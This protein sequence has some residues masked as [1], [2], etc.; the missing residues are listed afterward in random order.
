[1]GRSTVD[2][3]TGLIA[4]VTEA[5]TTGGLKIGDAVPPASDQLGGL[6]LVV[7]VAG[8]SI[9]ETPGIT[10]DAGDWCLCVNATEGWIR[11]DTLNGGGGGG[12]SSLGDLLDVTLTAEAAGEFIQLQ[13]NGQWQNI[14]LEPGTIGALKPGDNVS[15][16]VNDAGYLVPGDDVSDLN[17]DAGYITSGDIPAGANLWT[18]NTGKVYPTNLSNHVQVG[19]TAADP[20]IQLNASGAASF[21]GPVGIGTDSP[22]GK[23]SVDGVA[24]ANPGNNPLIH[25]SISD[26]PIWAFRSTS[27][28]THL[29]I[30]GYYDGSWKNHVA[31]ERNSGSVGIGGTLP[32]APNISLNASGSAS[33]EG[34][35]G[36]GTDLPQTTLQVTQK[37]DTSAD[38][39]RLTRVGKT[40]AYTQWIDTVARFNIGYSNPATSD[41]A[42]SFVTLTQAGNVGI[43]TDSPAAPLEISDTG[44]GAGQ[45][46]RLERV[47]NGDKGQLHLS[48][49]PD[50]NTVI[51]KAT[52]SSPSSHVF[53][54]GNTE[55]ARIDTEGRLLVG[56]SISQSYGTSTGLVQIVG[57]TNAHMALKRST[58]DVSQCTF[59]FAKSRGTP[60]S[61]AI[62]NNNDV[63]GNLRYAAYDGTDY[64]SRAA[65]IACSVDGPPDTDNL[66]GRLTF[67]TTGSGNSSPTERMRIRSDGNIGIGT[68]GNTKVA[69]Y[70]EKEINYEGNDAKYSILNQPL[71]NSGTSNM[72]LNWSRA[73]WGASGDFTVS[74]ITHFVANTD[75]PPSNV[76]LA[77][78]I[79]FVAASNL[80]GATN[81]YGF[82]SDIASGTGRWNFY[83]NGTAANYFNGNTLFQSTT[84]S[85]IT[86]GA[87]NAKS[88]VASGQM[89]SSRSGTSE[90][91][92]YRFYNPNGEVGSIKTSGNLTIFEE[93]S[94]YRLKEN[95]SP[96]TGA[97]DQLKALKPC[98][99]N[100]KTDPNTTLQG[101]IAHEAQE[102]CPQAVTGA[103]DGTEAIGTLF[104]WDGK[105]REENVTEPAEL[106][107]SEEVIDDPGQEGKEAVYSEPV[108][109]QEYQP[110]VYG[111]P[112]LISPATEPVIGPM[113]RV[114][115][116]GKEAVYGDPVL[117]TPEV[118]EQW[119]EPEL[120]SPAVEHREPTYKTVTRQMSWTKTSDRDV[121]QGIDQSK[122]VPL[123]TAALQ[124]ALGR[125]EALEAAIAGS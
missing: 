70:L 64:N 74:E 54:T 92:H 21:E 1:M 69:F 66:P 80:T 48:I 117:I 30:D 115:Q 120:I 49:D 77:K 37:L 18:E 67:S 50:E 41:P 100:F 43:G 96:L 89:N 86:S 91:A 42:S 65:E 44:P 109:I 61:P 94:D 55:R 79:G 84:D 114:I 29:G 97:A 81:N 51:Y 39:I 63:L 95:I 52:G 11:I 71:I 124:E 105:V 112:E 56:T 88:I 116:E 99:Y 14:E 22:Q 6:Y 32:S 98:V 34:P 110:A 107:Y 90:L 47:N 27:G 102:V 60:D 31:I 113:G 5:G 38:G 93:S 122:L 20:N 119:S 106:T 85:N 78:Q 62:V 58:D 17:N 19:G 23:L 45:V 123:L 57:T 15:E 101:F 33:F 103:K 121:M 16:L 40:A 3:S 73:Q 111:E 13:A 104:D 9:S 4:G 36:I 12:A 82:Y 25:L 8:N 24:G 76:T 53:L 7:S 118:P 10:Y 83:A 68:G 87:A 72:R 35:V 125:I 46:M 75:T 59:T 108:L 26:A 2:A 28:N